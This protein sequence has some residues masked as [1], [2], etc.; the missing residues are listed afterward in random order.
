MMR[1]GVEDPLGKVEPGQADGAQV[2]RSLAWPLQTALGV[3]LS[4]PARPQGPGARS[5]R[6]VPTN[7]TRWRRSGL[8]PRWGPLLD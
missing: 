3:S 1:S 2:R 7:E 4:V 6:L 8:T 5:P